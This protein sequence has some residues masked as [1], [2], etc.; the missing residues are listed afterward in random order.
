MRRGRPGP[1]QEHNRSGKQAAGSAPGH[2]PRRTG[3]KTGHL[4]TKPHVP[5]AA[6]KLYVLQHR[7]APLAEL[8]RSELL[9]VSTLRLRF[10]SHHSA[11]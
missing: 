8:C 7:D 5:P 1:S 11:V 10:S 2:A 3:H 9:Q 4:Q 6:P